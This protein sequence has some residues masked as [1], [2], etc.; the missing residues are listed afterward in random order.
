MI[1]CD[2]YR[3]NVGIILSNTRGE[4]FWARRIGQNAWQF[5]QGGIQEQESPEEAMFRELQEE[6]GLSAEHVQIM[7]VT[8]D[9]L[10]YKLP[11]RYIRKNQHPVCI[12]QKQMWF[13]LRMMCNETAVNLKATD[14]PEFD[15]W[16]WVDYWLPSKQVIFFKRQVYREA[17]RQL[18]QFVE[19]GQ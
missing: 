3:P 18:K 5:P 11:P 4:V 8:S 15:H 12:G 17:L 10:K 9:W 7:G 6:T 16:R 13:M 1:D 14:K 2:G 19:P